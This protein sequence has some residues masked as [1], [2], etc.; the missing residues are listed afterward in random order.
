M[1]DGGP[2]SVRVVDGIAEIR[3]PENPSTGFAWVPVEGV[4]DVLDSRFEPDRSSPRALGAG[5]T[6]VIVVRVAATDELVLGLRRGW[7]AEPVEVRRVRLER[8]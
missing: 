4:L 6:R 3:I 5:G 8:D 7:Q 2:S 1:P